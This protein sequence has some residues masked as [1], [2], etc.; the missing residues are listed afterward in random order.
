MVVRTLSTWNVEDNDLL[1]VAFATMTVN[2]PG[3]Q[4][5]DLAQYLFDSLFPARGRDTPWEIVNQTSSTCGHCTLFQD[6]YQALR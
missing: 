1:N 2:W 5:E 4:R 3:T 6:I